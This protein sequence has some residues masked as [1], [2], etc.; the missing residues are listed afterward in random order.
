M[1]FNF[2]KFVLLVRSKEGIL[3]LLL[4]NSS[5]NGFCDTSSDCKRFSWQTKVTSNGFCVTSSE[6]ILCPPQSKY[7]SPG[8][9]VT[10]SDGSFPSFYA[11]VQSTLCKVLVCGRMSDF[12]VVYPQ[13]SSLRRVFCVKSSLASLFP[14]HFK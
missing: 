1:Q 10:S 4:N 14:V 11:F 2:F 7:F 6:G 5:S 8:L 13:Y 9:C 3:L 12:I